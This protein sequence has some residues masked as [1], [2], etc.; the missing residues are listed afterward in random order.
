MHVNSGGS[1]M[2]EGEGSDICPP[3]SPGKEGKKKA[4]NWVKRTRKGKKRVEK[5]VMI[6]KNK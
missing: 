3:P 5:K 2:G 4:H 1:V 6:L